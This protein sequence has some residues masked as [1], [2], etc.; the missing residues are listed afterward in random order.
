M[1]RLITYHHRCWCRRQCSVKTIYIPH[2]IRFWMNKKKNVNTNYD[3]KATNYWKLFD[4]CHATG[5]FSHSLIACK[6][7][8]F[9]QYISALQLQYFIDRGKN[10]CN[11]DAFFQTHKPR[12]GE[13][14]LWQLFLQFFLCF[15]ILGVAT[16]SR[17]N[18]EKI[19]HSY[20]RFGAENTNFFNR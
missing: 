9:F 10:E 7:H 1:Y 16:L 19:F 3:A 12:C 14:I 11:R 4:Y 2:W 18:Y 6:L 8:R 15:G 13:P 5:V 17:L 20:R